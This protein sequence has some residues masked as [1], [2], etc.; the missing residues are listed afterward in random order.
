MDAWQLIVASVNAVW[1]IGGKGTMLCEK[2]VHLF[3]TLGGT[4]SLDLF[5]LMKQKAQEKR[6]SI[7]QLTWITTATLVHRLLRAIVLPKR[8]YHQ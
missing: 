8:L 1:I 7:S 2:K 3:R 4:L 6:A 5:I